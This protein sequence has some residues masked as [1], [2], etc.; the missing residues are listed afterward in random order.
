MEKIFH[1]NINQLQQIEQQQHE[2]SGSPKLF[3]MEK[4]IM[5]F[6]A[7]H[8]NKHPKGKGAWNGRQIRNAFVIAA[9]LARYEAEQPGLAG[10]GFQPQLRYSHFQ[11]VEKLTDEYNRF[12]AHVLG[13]D[14]SRK[15][16]LNEERDDDYEDHEKEKTSDIV[17]RLKLARYL[18]MDQQ[19]GQPQGQESN[20]GAGLTT[21]SQAPFPTPQSMPTHYNQP[22]MGQSQNQFAPP[23]NPSSSIIPPYQSQGGYT[24]AGGTPHSNNIPGPFVE[25]KGTAAA[26]RMPSQVQGHGQVQAHDQAQGHGQVQAPGQPFTNTQN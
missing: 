13:G 1:T 6:A 8:Y 14:D 26:G 18:Y 17:D 15:A 19:Q 7:D 10:T 9:S 23:H 25:D 3:I 2:I 16:F 22:P 24:F 20:P 4:D 11:E 12:R 5:R 21:Y